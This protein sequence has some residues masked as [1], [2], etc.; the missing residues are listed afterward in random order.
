MLPYGKDPEFKS[1]KGY[2]DKGG[3][4]RLSL[5]SPS[6]CTC[7]SKLCAVT[8]RP[9]SCDAWSILH[10]TPWGPQVYCDGGEHLDTDRHL[11]PDGIPDGGEIVQFVMISNLVRPTC[12]GAF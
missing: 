11:M 9:P 12:S 1:L 8:S 4:G 5:A 2:T 6:S 7:C 3:F 10:M